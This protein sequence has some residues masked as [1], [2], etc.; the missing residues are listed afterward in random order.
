MR[1]GDCMSELTPIEQR[2]VPFQD[3]MVT[4]VM[5]QDDDGRE[6]IYVPL[7][8]LVEG[9][10]LDWSAQRKRIKKNIV[11]DKVCMSVA[12]TATDIDDDS[13]RPRTSNYLSIPIS[14]L[15]GFLFG[16]NARRVKDEI[17]PL[18][19]D[20]QE[21][22]YEV[23][24]HAF[25]GVDSMRRFYTAVGFDQ[26]WIETRIQ[27]HKTGT[28]LGDYWLISGVPIQ[29]HDQLQDELSKGTFGITTKE[30]RQIKQLPDDANLNDNMSRIE[31][32]LS[33]VADEAA[34][35][36]IENEA[37]KGIDEHTEAAQR[38]GSIAG[39][40]RRDFEAQTGAKVVSSKN[41]LDKKKRPLLDDKKDS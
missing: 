31:L 9:M 18:L 15:N 19:I 17:R 36:I 29:Y 12:V 5:V 24:F 4:A 33:M 30:H 26:K 6:N 32:A 14:H 27:K 11:L 1:I 25:N 28:E 10:G 41:S 38:A 34:I 20:Y 23:L 39:N 37:T 8:L 3:G 7:R 13:K 16:I 21:K 2:E 22:C 40:T 35:A